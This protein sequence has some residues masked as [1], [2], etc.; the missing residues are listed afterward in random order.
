[1]ICFDKITDLFCITDE[2][3]KNFEKSTE[4]FLIGNKAKRK[5]RMSSAEVITVYYLFHL[6]VFVVLSITTYFTFKSTCKKSFQ[7]LFLIIVL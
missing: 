1:M 3:C 5:P 2:F 6:R 7:T 4:F